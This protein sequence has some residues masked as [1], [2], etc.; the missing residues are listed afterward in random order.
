[1]RA[2]ES[3]TLNCRLSW[4]VSA[5]VPEENAVG[6]SSYGTGGFKHTYID[7]GFG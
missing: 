2:V 6:L 1:M 5:V 7:V 3:G 4:A